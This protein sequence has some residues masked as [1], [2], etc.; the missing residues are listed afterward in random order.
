MGISG[1]LKSQGCTLVGFE[2][3]MWTVIKDGHVILIITHIDDSS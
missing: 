3:S 1:A 2:R